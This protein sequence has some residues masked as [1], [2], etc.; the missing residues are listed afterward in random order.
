MKRLTCLLATLA[1][2][3][4]SYVPARAM[5]LGTLPKDQDWSVEVTS[6][7]PGDT[8][9]TVFYVGHNLD[10][11]EVMTVPGEAIAEQSFPKPGARVKRII[12]EVDSF[13][14]SLRFN[15]GAAVPVDGGYLH[16]VFNVV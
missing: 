5:P 1:M 12:I 3:I 4:C 2:V 13:R 16:I 7:T 10:V 6:Q 9:L 8:T 11:I 15:H 14:A